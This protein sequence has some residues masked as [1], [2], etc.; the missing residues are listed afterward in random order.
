MKNKLSIVFII[1]LIIGF[2]L[3]VYTFEYVDLKG[4]GNLEVY[5]AD[6]Y[7]DPLE[8]SKVYLN[9]KYMGETNSMGSKLLEN[10]TVGNYTVK[11][12]K[13]GF[14]N[15]SSTTKV[16]DNKTN[17]IYITLSKGNRGRLGIVVVDEEYKPIKN[18][19]I[20]LDGEFVGK[21]NEE[22]LKLL[23]DLEV[24]EH[25]VKAGKKDYKNKTSDARVKS[26]RWNQF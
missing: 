22:G 14:I 20:Y 18:P 23:E 13:K 21:G 4:K 7:N 24:G 25:R 8:Y 11:V 26:G 3:L 5:V 6:K 19:K 17:F 1:S 15:K 10:L 12:S 2:G 16:E 9:G